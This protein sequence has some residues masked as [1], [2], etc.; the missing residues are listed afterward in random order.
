MSGSFNAKDD[1]G[2]MGDGV[3]NDTPA[4]NQALEACFTQGKSLYIPPGVYVLQEVPGTKRCLLNRGVSMKGDGGNTKLVF[5]PNVSNNVDMMLI[6]PLGG[7]DFV[8][9]SNIWWWPAYPN[10]STSVRGR[11]CI[12][13]LANVAGTNVGKLSITGNYFLPSND[14]SIE[15]ENDATLLP[16]GNPSN[17]LF[18]DNAFWGGVKFSNIGDSNVFQ[19]NVVRS[20]V[21]KRPG[22]VI[23]V[24]DGAG[25][26]A[27][28][29]VFRDNNMDCYSGA[30]IL[31][32]GRQY[33]IDGN[34]IEQSIGC[35]T[36]YAAVIDID[37]SSGA[38]VGAVITNNR[39]GIFDTAGYAATSAQTGIRIHGSLRANVS[40]NTLD[41]NRPRSQ[42]I[43]ITGS[44]TSTRLGRNGFS[45]GWSYNVNNM[46]T[47][48]KTISYV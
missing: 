13:F 2:A 7:A 35:G 34:N 48:T 46:G 10:F 6:N 32:N 47:D 11:R 3:T 1:F 39:I 42:G 30:M 27:G 16:Q 5:S 41:T 25:G 33:I 37:G 36:D 20:P 17:S 43:L 22:F 28:H 45:G 9:I 38:I 44:A 8:S 31:L 29:N 15:G 4:L 14:Y 19:R 23:Y 18:A 21:S 40:E 24:V 12:Y 26:S